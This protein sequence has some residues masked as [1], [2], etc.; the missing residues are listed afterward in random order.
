MIYSIAD[1]NILCLL[2][3]RISSI[4]FNVDIAGGELY[5]SAGVIIRD[6]RIIL[7]QFCFDVLVLVRLFCLFRVATFDAIDFPDDENLVARNM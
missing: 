7:L 2:A 1:G 5:Q 3:L 4:H 6:G